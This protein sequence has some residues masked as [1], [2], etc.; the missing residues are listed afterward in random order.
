ME[1]VD[2]AL[3][4]LRVAVGVTM[5]LHGWNKVRNGIAGTAKWF[6]SM[7]MKPG[8]LNAWLAAGTEIGGGVLLAVGLLTPFAG[9]SIV[10]LMVVA[11]WTSHR[12]KG[13]FVFRPGQGWEYVFVLAVVG[14][15]VGAIGAGQWSLDAAFG[16]VEDGY[17]DGW[18]GALVAGVLGVGGGIAQM[19]VFYRPPA[20]A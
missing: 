20:K 16:I 12:D 1:H 14:F 3:F 19:A 5:A 2:L 15:A 4:V 18:W 10:G 7:G 17:V 11:G 9:A 13:F 8:V 6:D